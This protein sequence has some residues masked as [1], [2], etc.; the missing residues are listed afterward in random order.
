MTSTTDFPHPYPAVDLVLISAANNGLQLVLIRWE[1]EPQP[2][3][4]LPGAYVQLG[5]S[6][7]ETGARICRTKLEMD[8][9]PADERFIPLRPFSEH[10]RDPRRGTISLPRLA[11][12]SQAEA[13]RIGTSSGSGSAPLSAWAK[14]ASDHGGDISIQGTTVN[15]VFDHAGIVAEAVAEL[16]RRTEL[17]DL[18]PLR[19]LLPDPF[20]LRRLQVVH[21]ALLGRSV[22]R[23]S[24]RRKMLASEGLL[25]PTGEREEDVEHRPAELYRWRQGQ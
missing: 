20:T 18:G 9:P 7:E 25:E 6:V 12:L 15:L 22:N 2:G 3:W 17:E 1:R 14:L 11:L 13:Q 4:A 21:E 10:A 5:D 16:R 23:D 24:F 19:Q 8:E